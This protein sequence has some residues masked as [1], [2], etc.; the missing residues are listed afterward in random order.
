MTEFLTVEFSYKGETATLNLYSKFTCICGKDSG[1]GKTEFLVMLEEGISEGDVLITSTSQ[2]P[3][4]TADNV[5]ISSIL[6]IKERRIIIIDEAAMLRSNHMGKINKSN[7]IF[8]CISRSLP[9]GGDFPLK[10]IYHIKRTENWFQFIQENE[11]PV[12]RECDLES[13][14]V[15]EA[16]K[17]RSE[18]QLLSIYLD[19]IIAADG[20]DKIEKVVRRLSGKIIVVADLGN[21]GKAY[22][23]LKKRC[24]QNPEIVFYDYQ[25]FE[26]LLFKSKLINGKE[27]GSSLDR[28]SLISLE[29]YYELLLEEKTKHSD[30]RYE[31]GKNLPI[32]FLEKEKFEVIFNTEVGKG[33]YN[34]IKAINH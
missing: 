24:K 19:N 11:L 32:I 6:E 14:I 13:I 9:L 16:R 26:E 15:T 1:E 3:V 28:F 2:I 31:H 33:F 5:N 17:G 29:E 8:I 18:H 25:A 20:R 22:R 27:E 21:I 34:L 7:H 30:F 12:T 10:G 4:Y 23:L